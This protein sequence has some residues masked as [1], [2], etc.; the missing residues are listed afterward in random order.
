MTELL[1]AQT[2]KRITLKGV[3]ECNRQIQQLLITQQKNIVSFISKVLNRLHCNY[4]YS[5]YTYNIQCI[6]YTNSVCF[7]TNYQEVLNFTILFFRQS[8]NIYQQLTIRIHPI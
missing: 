1:G 6:S 5:F 8:M 4:L 2:T 7:V 3:R